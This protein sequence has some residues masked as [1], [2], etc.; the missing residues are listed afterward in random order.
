MNALK[1]KLVVFWFM[2]LSSAFPGW[3]TPGIPEGI[4][5]FYINVTQFS[6]PSGMIWKQSLHPGE[7]RKAMRQWETM[8]ATHWRLK[9][10]PILGQE[11]GPEDQKD[12]GTGTHSSSILADFPPVVPGSPF[13]G[14]PM[15]S[16][17]LVMS[18][19]EPNAGLT[20]YFFFSSTIWQ[21]IH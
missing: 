5:T 15:T 8:A 21:S 3:G 12:P 14:R 2:H 18:W 7:I 11:K 19:Q 4:A 10:S 20:V 1:R 6:E 13:P 16:V 9:M 17:L